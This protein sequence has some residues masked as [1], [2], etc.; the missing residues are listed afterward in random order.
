MLALSAACAV[1]VATDLDEVSANKVIAGLG[2]NGVAADKQRDPDHEGRFS[3]DVGRGDASF[4][5]AVMAREELPPQSAP[6]WSETLARGSFIPSRS[7][8]EAKLLLATAGELQRSLL[9]VDRVIAARVHLAVARADVLALQASPAAPTASVLL[10]HGGVEPPISES[11][12]SRLIAG[13]VPGLA[14]AGV[15]VVMKAV[16]DP[17]D[18]TGTELVRLGPLT[19]TRSSLPYLRWMIACV[20]TLNASMVALLFALW[21][22]MRRTH[23]VATAR[24]DVAAPELAGRQASSE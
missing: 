2:R 9:S 23:A 14:P 8:E 1:P 19:T 11:D 13:A 22:R 24:R 12:V 5:L 16:S 4:A 3:V 6:G 7:D 20:A 10:K 21:W 15:T 18:R 17:V